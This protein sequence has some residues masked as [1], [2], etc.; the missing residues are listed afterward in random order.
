MQFG[1]EILDKFVDEIIKPE[2]KSRTGMHLER[3]DDN[4]EAGIIDNRM[5]RL[6]QD[7]AFVI[8]DL[9]HGNNGAYWEAGYAEGLGKP[10]IYLCE[11][12]AFN[13]R[14]LHF[15]VNHSMTVMWSVEDPNKAVEQLAATILNSL[16][17]Q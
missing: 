11:E 17:K 16:P 6:I 2:I 3:V 5:R 1:D 13:E 12:S 15:D 10:V 7:A 4:P 14:K 9:T 8:A